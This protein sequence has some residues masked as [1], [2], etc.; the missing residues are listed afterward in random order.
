MNTPET[1]DLPAS[2]VSENAPVVPPIAGGKPKSALIA[3]NETGVSLKSMEEI[4]IFAKAVLDSGMA[5]RSFDTPQKI[6]VAVQMGMEIGLSPMSAL[7]NIAVINGKPTIYGDAVPGVCNAT[8]LVENCKDET[9]GV[10]DTDTWGYRV[11]VQR[12]GRADPVVRTFTVKDAKRA[13]LWGK[14]GPW[15][16]YPDRMLLMRARTFALRDAF[17]DALRGLPTYEES[18]DHPQTEKNVTASLS[19][20]DKPKAP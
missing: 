9:V 8:G 17:P 5:P 4:F 6:L 14:T 7:Q 20:L 19:D 12:K 2:A 1:L 3:V 16:Q 11:T 10:A 15:S 18:R 13:S